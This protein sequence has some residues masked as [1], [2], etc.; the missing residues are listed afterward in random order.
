MLI[1]AD[2]DSRMNF[3]TPCFRNSFLPYLEIVGLALCIRKIEAVR[4]GVMVRSGDDAQWSVTPRSPTVTQGDDMTNVSEYAATAMQENNIRLVGASLHFSP[5][6][7]PINTE[8]KNVF[9][10]LCDCNR[11]DMYTLLSLQH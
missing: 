10:R 4:I 3:M 6:S 9:T 7:I 5:P 11:R 1:V 8:G 2:D